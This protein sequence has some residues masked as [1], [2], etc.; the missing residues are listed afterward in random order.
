[1]K[2]AMMPD[3][4]HHTNATQP[5]AAGADDAVGISIASRPM[6]KP[7]MVNRIW[8]TNEANTPA[9]TADQ[10]QPKKALGTVGVAMMNSSRSTI[11]WL[12]NAA[13]THLFPLRNYRS[14]SLLVCLQELK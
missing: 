6:P 8:R 9:S 13:F 14:G 7:S 10:V 2:A 4:A 5:A 3:T 1:M 11:L 12:P